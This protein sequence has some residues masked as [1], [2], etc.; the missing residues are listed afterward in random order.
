MAKLPLS[1][2]FIAGEFA[3]P[4]ASRLAYANH[5]PLRG[6][7]RALG[8]PARDLLAGKDEALG[9]L[10]DRQDLPADRLRAH[11]PLK[12]RDTVQGPVATSQRW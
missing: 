7:L 2:P 9:R 6:F 3:A 1:I 10:A 8:L 11:T 4:T 12:L 5:V